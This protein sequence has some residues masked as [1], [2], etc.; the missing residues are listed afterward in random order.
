M[1]CAICSRQ[2]LA[3]LESDAFTPAAKLLFT[4]AA[5]WQAVRCRSTMQ[6]AQIRVHIKANSGTSTS[7]GHFHM[8]LWMHIPAAMSMRSKLKDVAVDPSGETL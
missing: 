8:Q 3:H 4:C 5:G 7:K 6:S 2:R 1:H